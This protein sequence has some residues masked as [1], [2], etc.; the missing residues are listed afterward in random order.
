MRPFNAKLHSGMP[1]LRGEVMQAMLSEVT[2][3]F[4]IQITEL[5]NDKRPDRLFGIVSF[6]SLISKLLSKLL[7][8]SHCF[9]FLYNNL[10][11]GRLGSSKEDEEQAQC[12]DCWYA[13]QNHQF[14][15]CIHVFNPALVLQY[16]CTFQYVT[17]D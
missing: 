12:M 6:L 16:E 5:V 4:V 13:N 11:H 2:E 9:L 8:C 1:T 15:H 7:G 3:L 14:L 10:F 17:F